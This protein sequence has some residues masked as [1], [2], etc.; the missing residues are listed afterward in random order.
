[1]DEIML[2]EG[3]I[4]ALDTPTE[5]EDSPTV[6]GDEDIWGFDTSE[7]VETSA[8]DSS[9]SEPEEANQPTE[10]AVA[11]A[12]SAN[13]TEED[14]DTPDFLPVKYNH[15]DRKLSKKEA[16][17]Y[18]QMGMNYD[19]VKSQ[20]D[21]ANSVL[22]QY[23]QYESFLNDIKGDFK[24]IE[25]LMVDTRARMIIENE[26]AKGNTITY[27]S[28]VESVKRNMPK[29]PDARKIQADNAVK[30]FQYRRK[31]VKGEEIPQ[32]VWDDVKITG[33]LVG[34]YLDYECRQKDAKIKELEKELAGFKQEAK[35]KSR[36]IGSSK[37]SGNKN[38]T[39]GLVDRI[40][41]SLG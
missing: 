18:A 35:N 21:D 34:A 26:K 33:D 19:K 23:K 12:E 20:L 2:N 22:E 37:S 6:L 14:E 38:S 24:T 17:T 25:E 9:D 13:G 31:N 29:L 16:Q 32:E 10:E 4:E 41:D 3:A 40:W 39:K 7:L 27:D 1:M 28:A 36:T 5:S 11:E 30:L 8:D 15:E